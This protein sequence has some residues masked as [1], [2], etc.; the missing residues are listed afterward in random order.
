MRFVIVTGMSGSG[1]TAALKMLEDDGYFCVDNLPLKLIGKFAELAGNPAQE[2][3]KVAVGFDSR[4]LFRGH[5]VEEF[6][7]IMKPYTFEILYLD[8]SNQELVR[9]YKATRRIHP[10]QKSGRIEDGIE[11]ER[12][13][14]EPLRMRAD[15]IIDTSDMLTRQLQQ[16][17]GHIFLKTT[18]AGSIFLSILSFGYKYGIPSDADLVFDVRFL[19]NPFYVDEL[20]HKTGNDEDVQAY[21]CQ[22][23][24]ADQFLGKLTDL[25][26]FLIPRYAQEGKKQLTIAVGCTGGKHRSVTIANRLNEYFEKSGEYPVV[27]LHRDIGR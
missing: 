12:K 24:E 10:L 19:P 13:L 4:S 27:L 21:V 11:K 17:I 18:G 6:F 7:R 26:G 25:L 14:L 8:C 5:S 1:K 9:R 16:E 23:G 15:Y 22:N 20:K 2:Y 3:S